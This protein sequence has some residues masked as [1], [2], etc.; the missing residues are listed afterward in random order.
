MKT[1]LIAVSLVITLL[2]VNAQ[3]KKNQDIA[4]IKAMCGCHEV[5]F[6]FAETFAA[7]KDYEFHDNYS[8]GAT[9]YVL[10]VEESK[11]KIAIQHILVMGEYIVKHWRQ[12]WIYENTELYQYDKDNSWNYVSLPKSTVDGQWTQLV[13]QVDDSPRYG[14]TATWVHVDDRSFWESEADAPLP[15]REFSKRDDYNVMKRI[16]HHEITDYGWLHEQDNQ[17]VQR[18]DKQDKLIAHEKGWNTYTKIDQK[19]CQ[20]AIDWWEKNNAYWADV[21]GVWDELFNTRQKLTLKKSVDDEPLHQKL[22]A[23]GDQ[24]AESESYQSEAS[25]AQIK[26][27]IEEYLDGNAKFV[28]LK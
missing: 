28:S 22:F 23:L 8:A 19:E 16:N 14:G 3:K 18:D 20:P 21:R 13:Y 17:K 6:N 2:P 7:D 27:V 12:D 15:R 9:E 10:V 25:R 11:H 24:M 4:A 26:A 5:E 1:I